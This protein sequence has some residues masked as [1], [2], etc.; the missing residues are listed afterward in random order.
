MIEIIDERLEKLQENF[1]I[2]KDIEKFG[3]Q[4]EIDQV[5]KS[6][7]L[8]ILKDTEF[9]K[10]YKDLK[11]NKL[12]TNLTYEKIAFIAGALE[13]TQNRIQEVKRT[14]EIK[15]FLKNGYTLS[16]KKLKEKYDEK[17]KELH[18][19]L[20]IDRLCDLYEKPPKD[21]E[22]YYNKNLFIILDS[23]VFRKYILAIIQMVYNHMDLVVTFTGAE[24]SGK[25]TKCSQDMYLVWWIL[26]ECKIITYKFN[27]KDSFFNSLH[28]LRATEDKYFNEP[29][30]ILALDEGN[31]LNRQNWKDD[32]VNMFFQRLRRERYNKRI[33]FICIPVLGEML[34]NI[35]LS[36]VN[37]V[38]E[39][40]LGNNIESGTLSKGLVN[41]YIIPRS[42]HIYSPKQKREISKHFI[43]TTLETNLKD[44]SYLKGV[45]KEILIKKIESNGIW[46]F[47]EKEYI[48]ELKETNDTFSINKQL[49]LSENESYCMYRS[50][51]SMKQQG[52]NSKDFV[53]FPIVKFL[54]RINK[55]WENNIDL[56]KKYDEKKKMKEITNGYKQNTN[57]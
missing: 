33:K 36:R 4:T 34:T 7:T 54:T 43:Q 49:S 40:D 41:F 14:C 38:F 57:K 42:K 24:G 18:P 32:E 13:I 6:E 47:P 50:G 22:T 44:K 56:L 53:Y 55:F 27:I 20:D 17:I 21:L 2:S 10:I 16:R 3:S 31:E 52:I 11:K 5:S 19:N 8:E 28:K 9:N 48:K 25:S 23:F 26:T 12:S 46:G 30:R 45:P 37:F 15:Y 51:I 35:I 1:D 39:M 29:Y